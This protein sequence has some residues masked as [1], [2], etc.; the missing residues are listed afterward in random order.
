MGWWRWWV[1]RRWSRSGAVVVAV[2]MVALVGWWGLTS[3]GRG[4]V[5][6]GNAD[7]PRATASMVL[8][9]ALPPRSAGSPRGD[10]SAVWS[11][12]ERA[13]HT[14]ALLAAYNCIRTEH[15]LPGVILDRALS[16]TAG[17]AWAR[18]A[19]DPAF[20][21]MALP[22]TYLT[23]SV[24]PLDGGEPGDQTNEPE[25]SLEAHGCVVGGFDPRVLPLA[26]QARLVGIAVFPP[27]ARW[28]GAS[29]VVL[30]KE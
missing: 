30:V 9:T 22:G 12:A 3:P 19:D 2:L 10:A 13:R 1:R 5:F 21:L 15:G 28:D 20:S 4:V 29:A 27:Q 26:P 16:V 7:T 14:Q 6:L 24:V 25:D 23:R 17:A 8:R 18:L 11:M